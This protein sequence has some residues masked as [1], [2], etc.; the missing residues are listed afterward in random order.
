VE[1]RPGQPVAQPG[2]AKAP[3][4]LALHYGAL[5]QFIAW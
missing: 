5:I 3:R 4:R 2:A 1:R